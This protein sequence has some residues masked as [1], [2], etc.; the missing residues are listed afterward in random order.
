MKEENIKDLMRKAEDLRN[1]MKDCSDIEKYDVD[2]IPDDLI[3]KIKAYM[4]DGSIKER[5]LK[6]INK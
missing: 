2:V 4:I 6:K 3:I 5:V 1:R